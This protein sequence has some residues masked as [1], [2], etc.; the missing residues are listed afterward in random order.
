MHANDASNDDIEGLIRTGSDDEQDEGSDDD[1]GG[2]A[3]SRPDPSID[4]QDDPDMTVSLPRSSEDSSNPP[5]YEES[6]PPLQ[7][8]SKHLGHHP[9]SR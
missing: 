7:Q 8:P 5:S 4:E 3:H 9:A 2:D 6:S 1:Y